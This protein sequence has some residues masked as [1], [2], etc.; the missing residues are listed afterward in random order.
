MR[1]IVDAR[2]VWTLTLIRNGKQDSAKGLSSAQFRFGRWTSEVLQSN[3]KRLPSGLIS[4][5]EEGGL[6]EQAMESGLVVSMVVASGEAVGWNQFLSTVTVEKPSERWTGN[7][8]RVLF[9]AQGEIDGT[10][11]FV[12]IYNPCIG[13]MRLPRRI[14]L[15][16]D[17]L[18]IG[19]LAWALGNGIL[20]GENTT[21]M[22]L[23]EWIG[24]PIDHTIIPE[25]ILALP[26]PPSRA[27]LFEDED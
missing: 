14:W 13:G 17:E 22:T 26:G 25:D 6:T 7:R 2:T 24:E 9:S 18:P 1:R 11:E 15:K 12:D 16:V 10:L 20:E 21:Q 23:S 8:T 3:L 5:I 19:T 4:M 27:Y